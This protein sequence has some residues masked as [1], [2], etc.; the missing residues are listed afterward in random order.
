MPDTVGVPV[1]K[2]RVKLVFGGDIMV[3]NGDK[4]PILSAQLISLINSSDLFIA[5]LEAPLGTHAPDNTK[6]YTFKFHMPR[7]FLDAIQQQLGLPYEKWVLTNANNH[8]GDAGIA[9]F[10]ESIALLDQLGVLH[11]GHR[12][13]TDPW[14]VVDIKGI[15][16]GLAGWTHWLNR[17]V[18]DQQQP[19]LA[20]QEILQ[21]GAAR[22]SGQIKFDYVIGL[23]HW[24]YEFQHF[25]EKSCLRHARELMH[26]GFDLLLG[27]HPH[28][29]QPYEI[30]NGKYCF[31]SLGNFCGLGVA[32]PVKIITILELHLE[33]SGTETTVAYFKHHYFYQLH[34]GEE[35]RIVPLEDLTPVM[36]ERAEERLGIVIERS[37]RHHAA[38]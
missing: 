28:V 12:N 5:N 29:L 13:Y 26:N 4:P 19:V 22:A 8:S 38:L 36:R 33:K 15:K 27:S 14:R 21:H 31:Y 1:G 34:D 32:W 30:I 16:L 23:P 6:K 20:Y 7:A 17:G 11:L 9:G 24:G 2:N 18:F 35:I 37:E 10:D 3:L 25:P